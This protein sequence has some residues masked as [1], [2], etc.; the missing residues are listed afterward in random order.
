MTDQ[1]LM[2]ALHEFEMNH[3]IS[4]YSCRDFGSRAKGLA[5]PDSDRDAL[6]LFDQDPIYYKRLDGEIDNIT[7]EKNGIDFQ[8]W[9][10]RKFAELLSD[11]NPTAIEW[12]NSPENYYEWERLTPQL[13]EL[14][15]HATENFK[16]IALYYHYRSLADRQYFK[17]IKSQDDTT[18]DPSLKRN[19][20]AI[21][22]IACA[23][24]IR[25]TLEFP[26]MKIGELLS[27]ANSS[28]Q[29][30]SI[31][32]SLTERKRNGEGDKM[33]GNEYG[34][35]IEEWLE[36]QPDHDRLE[37]RGIDRKLCNRFIEEA[38]D[39]HGY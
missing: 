30:I 2:N 34:D 21:R 37:T 1:D 39:A 7:A 16:P 9:N 14:Q 27:E 33:I 13:R 24:Y 38:T 6:F 35:F 20:V 31:L 25:D 10:T 18:S 5:G 23:E 3:D 17:H 11:S 4:I 22:A 36:F 19:L 15:R 29:F 32:T 12:L 28:D 26:P 8:G